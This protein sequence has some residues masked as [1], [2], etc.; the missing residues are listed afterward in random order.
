MMLLF[1]VETDEYR[2][3]RIFEIKPCISERN[4]IRLPSG[5]FIRSLQDMHFKAHCRNVERRSL[6]LGVWEHYT[7]DNVLRQKQ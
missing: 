4:D 6:Y 3:T 5:I 1:W 2:D 7:E